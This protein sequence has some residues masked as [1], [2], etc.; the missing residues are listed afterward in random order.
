VAGPEHCLEDNRDTALPK[1]GA[2]DNPFEN[3]NKRFFAGPL[4]RRTIKDSHQKFLCV[5]SIGAEY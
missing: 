2:R 4:L 1:S 3:S 5:V